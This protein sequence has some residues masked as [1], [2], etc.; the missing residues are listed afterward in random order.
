MKAVENMAHRDLQLAKAAKNDEFY[1]QY[2]DIQKE[3][4]NYIDYN[5][6]V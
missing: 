5:P 2:Q 3:V 6:H 1:T 4:E